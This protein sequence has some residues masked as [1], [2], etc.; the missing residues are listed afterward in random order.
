MPELPEV[1]TVRAGLA[2]VLVGRRLTRVEQRRPDLRFPL[3]DQ[4]AERLAGRTIVD[5][6]RRSKYLLAHLDD[7]HVLVMHLGMTGRFTVNAPD[8]GAS[9]KPGRFVRAA[10][11]EAVHDHIVFHTGDGAAVTYND[12]RRFGFMLLIPSVD[13]AEHPI[14][15]NLGIEPLGNALSAGYLA[16][17]AMGA[18]RDLKAFLMDQRVIAGLGNIY[19]CEALYRARLSPRRQAATLV[20]RKGAPHARATALVTA[21]REVLRDA[22]AA[23]GSTLRDYRLADGSLGYFQHAF[24]VYGREG[25]PCSRPGCR[26]IVRRTTQAGRSTFACPACQR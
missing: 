20:D 14:I 10:G 13:L 16:E 5:L 4:F 9:G 25:E 22:L 19:V 18:R 1:E 7:G 26:G 15:R 2:P 8:R 12:A 6:S 17:R 11:G 3:P 23:G 21:V 24:A